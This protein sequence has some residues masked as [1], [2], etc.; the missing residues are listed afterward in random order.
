MGHDPPAQPQRPKQR[1]HPKVCNP[2]V[3]RQET[4]PP[5][6]QCKQTDHCGCHFVIWGQ[7]LLKM[8]MSSRCLESIFVLYTL[9]DTIV[10]AT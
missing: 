6:A 4:E 7:G 1:G 10:M 8:P 9:K 2:L 5:L 3:T